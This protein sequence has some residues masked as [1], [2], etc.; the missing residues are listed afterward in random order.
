MVSGNL[1]LVRSICAAW[2]RGE[3][4][5]VDWADPGIEYLIPDGPDPGRWTGID[6]MAEGWRGFLSAWDGARI[7]VDEYRELDDGRVLVVFSRQGRGKTSGVDLGAIRS[8]GANLFEL[9]DGKVTRLA[10]YF[11]LANA[12]ADVG[13]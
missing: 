12:L 9:R 2:E 10:L 5:W 13:R 8:Q 4:A 1:E 7:D 11:E 3:Y 6:G